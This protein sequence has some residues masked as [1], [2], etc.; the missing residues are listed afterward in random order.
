MAEEEV[1]VEVGAPAAGAATVTLN[2]PAR[3]NALT[4]AMLERLLGALA[5]LE[6]DPRVLVVVLA[7][8]GKF[9]CTGMDL[10]GGGPQSLAAGATENAF[11]RLAAFGKPHS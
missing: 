2:R 4:G 9:F 7:A 6:G 8:R 5:Q 10:G 1:L 3:G 11:A